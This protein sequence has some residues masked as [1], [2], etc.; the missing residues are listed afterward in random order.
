MSARLDDYMQ[1]NARRQPFGDRRRGHSAC[2]GDHVV[3]AD[4]RVP[5]SDDDP[6]GAIGELVGLMG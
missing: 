5:V 1:I 3:G 4:S 6:E 2:K